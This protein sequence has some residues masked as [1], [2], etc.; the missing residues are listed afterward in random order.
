MSLEVASILFSTVLYCTVLYPVYGIPVPAATM[1]RHWVYT[2]GI[3]TSSYF[4]LATK[5]CCIPV[6]GID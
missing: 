1:M 6:T 4:C 5:P 2:E 3:K